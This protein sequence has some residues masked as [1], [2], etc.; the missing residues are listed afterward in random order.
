MHR[1]TRI[2]LRGSRKILRMLLIFTK[3]AFLTPTRERDR[4]SPCVRNA[5]SRPVGESTGPF[6]GK[7]SG[8]P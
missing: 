7:F 3:L 2:E 8:P 4:G 6:Q 1:E 5:Y